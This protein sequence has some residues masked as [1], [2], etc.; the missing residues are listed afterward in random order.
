MG[1]QGEGLRLRLFRTKIPTQSWKT[2]ANA[3][4][5]ARRHH[6]RTYHPD[7]VDAGRLRRS[8]YKL[9]LQVVSHLSDQVVGWRCPLCDKGFLAEHTSVVA[10][11]TV[12]RYAAVHRDDAHTETTKKAWVYLNQAKSFVKRGFSRRRA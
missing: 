5:M 2:V 11:N 1:M 10:K 6:F 4:S 8:D 9:D 12:Q 3:V 7:M